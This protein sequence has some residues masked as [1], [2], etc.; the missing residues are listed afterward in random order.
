MELAARDRYIDFLRAA[1]ILVVVLGH[2]LMAVVTLSGSRIV[3]GNL[4]ADVDGLWAA[5]WALQV[6]P[7]FFVVGGFANATTLSGGNLAYA[8]F[9]RRRMRRLLTPVWVL[10]A[11]WLPLVALVQALHLVRTDD[12]AQ[13]AI[14]VTQLLWFVGVYALVIAPAP[15]ML[16]LH[17]RF[18][19]RVL[20]VL[21]G[22]VALVDILRFR[23][24][25]PIIG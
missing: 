21:G 2:W 11:V 13:S 1:S 5:T 17:R 10:L 3:V 9:V 12:L 4:I 7:V 14:V 8:T 6:M 25:V 18:G 15:W 22:A 20:A 24:G 19:V 16:R 23:F